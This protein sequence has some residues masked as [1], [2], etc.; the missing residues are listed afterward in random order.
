MTPETLSLVDKVAIITGS[1]RENGIGAGIAE[2][3]ARNGASVTIN[4]VSDSTGPQATHLVEALRSKYRVPVV[5]I[6]ADVT[7]TDGASQLVTGTLKAFSVDH[8]DILVNN[9]GRGIPVSTLNASDEEIHTTFAINVFGPIYMVRAVMPHIP[10]GGRIVNVSSVYSKIS[11]KNLPLYNSSKAA[12]DSLTYTWAAE[13]GR[14]H[15]IT[16]NTVAP[17]P[18]DTDLLRHYCRNNPDKGQPIDDL[19]K[20]TRAGERFGRIEDVADAVLLLVQEKSR[21]ITGQYIDVGGGIVV[22]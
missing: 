2:A 16:V 13:F 20:M 18:V 14:S 21:W 6:Q 1:G 7:T 10:P 8:I 12:C 11:H 4:Y 3:L 22:D 19:V 17:G 5:A 15:G 9:A